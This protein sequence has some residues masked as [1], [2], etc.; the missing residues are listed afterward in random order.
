MR[1]RR[2]ADLVLVS[3]LLAAALLLAGADVTGATTGVPIDAVGWALILAFHLPLY[4]R[5]WFPVPVLLA[6]TAAATAYLALDYYHSVVTFAV[7]LAVFTVAEARP[8]KLSVPGALLGGAVLLY[9]QR[10][11]HGNE[12]LF[13]AVVVTFMIL[14]AW[15]FGDNSGRL[16]ERGRHLAY[17]TEQLRREQQERAHQAVSQEQGRIARELHDVVAHHMSVISV[18]AGLGRYVLDSDPQTARTALD[19]IAGTAHEALSEMRRLL[20]VLRVSSVEAGEPAQ[21]DAAPGLDRLPHLLERVRAAGAT[22]ESQAEG[23][24]VALP[25]GLAL[26]VYRVVQE[27]LTNVLKHAVPPEATVSLVWHAH[28]LAVT[29]ADR[30]AARRPESPS[31]VVRHGLIGMRERARIYGGTLSA[32]PRPE[33]GFEVRLTLPIGE[34]AD[35]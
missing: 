1:W 13:G 5:V 34:H 35:G 22:V 23:E 17:L 26:C 19:V 3:W 11:L 31:D 24:P 7:A 32:G 14:V 21:F 29:V 10:L 9:A 20:A 8:R 18:Q 28:A 6:V 25:P 30:G 15:G 4:V 16:R 33:G 12:R 27:S 2:L